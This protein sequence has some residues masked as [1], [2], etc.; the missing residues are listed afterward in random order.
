MV[1]CLQS[2]H[3]RRSH[4]FAVSLVFALPFI[5]GCGNESKP[6]VPTAQVQAAKKGAIAQDVPEVKSSRSH[7]AQTLT[8]VTSAKVARHP[9]EG[10]KESIEAMF[11]ENPS[12]ET[13]NAKGAD[14]PFKKYFAAPSCTLKTNGAVVESQGGGGLVLEI[15][16]PNELSARFPEISPK[17]RAALFKCVLDRT[18]EGTY[19]CDKVDCDHCKR[20]D[21]P[22]YCYCDD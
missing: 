9:L 13:A 21:I 16:G 11:D 19:Y 5:A 15:I 12:A 7:M 1:N 18:P 22:V 10:G 17:V 8:I 6:E 4:A 2:G 3:C 20:N 14:G